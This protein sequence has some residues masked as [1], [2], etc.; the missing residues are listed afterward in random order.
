MEEIQ[1]LVSEIQTRKAHKSHK[2][3]SSNF[4]RSDCGKSASLAN[5][6]SPTI[7]AALEE[8]PNSVSAL[9]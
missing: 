7:T 8:Q 9:P 4:I 2:G 3:T 1:S 5:Q 6:T